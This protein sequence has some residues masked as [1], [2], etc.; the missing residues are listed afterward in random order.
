MNMKCVKRQMVNGSQRSNLVTV[1][2]IYVLHLIPD[3]FKLVYIVHIFKGV[4]GCWTPMRD[5]ISRSE[6]K[7]PKS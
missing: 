4:L 5:E 1:L 2:Q 6:V 7:C 3:V